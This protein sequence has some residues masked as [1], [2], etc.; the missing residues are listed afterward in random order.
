MNWK[1][2]FKIGE[3]VLVIQNTSSF[4]TDILLARIKG[5]YEVGYKINPIK[6]FKASSILSGLGSNQYHFEWIEKAPLQ[7]YEEVCTELAKMKMVIS[8]QL[9]KILDNQIERIR[10]GFEEKVVFS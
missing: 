5:Y 9:L 8:L 2:I 4:V 6:R 3:E 1:P 10:M 7:Y